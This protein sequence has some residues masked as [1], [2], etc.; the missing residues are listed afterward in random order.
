M[1]EVCLLLAAFILVAGETRGAAQGASEGEAHVHE[2]TPFVKSGETEEETLEADWWDDDYLANRGITWNVYSTQFYQG[3]TAGGLD[4][5]FAYGG[6]VDYFLRFAGDEVKGWEGF[7]AAMHAETRYGEDVNNLSGMLSFPNFAMAFPKA[8]ENVTAVTA[9][10]ATQELSENLSVF[11]AKINSLDDFELNFTGERGVNRFMNSAAVANVINARAVP[12]STYGTGFT[13]LRDSETL[14]TFIVRDADNHAT[15]VDIHELFAHGA[16]LSGTLRLPVSPFGFRGQQKFGMNWNSRRFTSVDPATYVRVPGQGIVA[17]MESGSWALWYNFD[18]YLWVS[19]E[20]PNVGWGVFGM[21][22]V[23]DGNPNPIN[24]N[25]TLGLGGN[26][27]LPGREQDTFGLAYFWV[28]LSNEFKQLLASPLAPPGLAQR[29]E[30]GVE[31][32][33]NLA[34]TPW[35]FLTTDLQVVRPSQVNLD[36]TLMAGMR[37]VVSF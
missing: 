6:K 30:Q 14:F 32:F 20:D 12:Y 17:G 19:D 33:Y 8:N 35:C 7:S 5:G 13:V 31:L 9:F 4:Q 1:R 27:L 2:E 23:S 37:L 24:G 34:C 21:T 15:T 26:S 22:G 28:G 29:D 3:V 11:A 25:F 16:L 10:S 36:T 18:Q